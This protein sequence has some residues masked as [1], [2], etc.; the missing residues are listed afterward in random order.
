MI[1]RSKSWTVSKSVSPLTAVQTYTY[2][3]TDRQTD[4]QTIFFH[5]TLVIV[6]RVNFDS[7]III[8]DQ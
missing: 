3:N 8:R 4:E 7:I 2:I 5:M 1:N 6:E